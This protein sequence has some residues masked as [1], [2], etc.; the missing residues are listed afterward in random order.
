MKMQ[1]AVLS[2]GSD[3]TLTAAGGS[4]VSSQENNM[5]RFCIFGVCL[6]VKIF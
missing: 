4:E 5:A 1:L 6:F 3:S 2:G